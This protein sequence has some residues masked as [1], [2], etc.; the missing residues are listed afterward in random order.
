MLPTSHTRKG[1]ETV[2]YNEDLQLAMSRTKKWRLGNYALN[3]TASPLDQNILNELEASSPIPFAERATKGMSVNFG[4][5]HMLLKKF[6]VP[7]ALITMGNVSINGEMRLPITSSHFKK[8]IK[9]K[10]GEENMSQYHLWTTLPGGMILD[11]VILS[12]LSHDGLIEVDDMIPSERYIYGQ[13][14][15][16]PHH[17]QYV[18]LVVGL[19]FFVASGT[20]DQ[21]AMTYLMG[22]RFPKQYN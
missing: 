17:L 22:D 12:S 16:L 11:S 9:H 8:M 10:S 5:F 2:T 4:M 21:E 13:A 7:S 15:D 3:K 6:N 14:D 18:P 19:E 1:A 20:I